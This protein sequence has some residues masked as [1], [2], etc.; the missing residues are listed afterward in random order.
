MKKIRNSLL[1]LL[2]IRQDEQPLVMNLM[3]FQFFQGAG[4]AFF[5]TATFAMFLER[6]TVNELPLVF[7]LA[8][9]LLYFTGLVYSWLEHRMKIMQLG[10]I[11][12]LMMAISFI[13]F[14]VAYSVNDGPELLTFMLAWFY[15]LYLLNNLQFWGVASIMF[16][17][18]QSKRLFGLIS[19]GDIPAKFIGYSLASL[20]VTTLGTENL[21][22]AGLFFMLCSVP[23]LFRIAKAGKHDLDS[24]G[25][26]MHEIHIKT[27]KLRSILGSFTS[28][29]LIEKTAILAFLF[30]LCL[31]LINFIFY[32]EVKT[33][34]HED[35]E[36]A[37]FIALFLAGSRIFALIVKMIFTGRMIARLGFRRSLLITP[38]VL[39]LFAL[40]IVFSSK[41]SGNAH[42][43]FYI[44]GMM[45]ISADILNSAIHF[46]GFL[47]L[48]QPLSTHDRLRAH[49]IVKGIMDPF[50]YFLTG[51]FLLLMLR[52]IGHINLFTLNYVLLGLLVFW[53]IGIYQV[54]AEYLRTLVQ[55][56]TTRTFSNDRPSIVDKDAFRLI[57]GKMN[58]GSPMEKIYLLKMLVHNH[59][60]PEL[61]TLIS[62]ALLDPAAAV[63]QE[64]IKVAVSME[65]SV[66][67]EILKDFIDREEDAALIEQ[68]LFAL[69]RISYD[70]KLVRGLNAHHNENV[71][72][73]AISV[74]L[75]H[76]ECSLH[77]HA[78]SYLHTLASDLDPRKRKAAANIIGKLSNMH[79]PVILSTLI[80]DKEEEVSREAIASAG[81]SAREE[82]IRVLV[83]LLP[84]KSNEVIE[85]LAEAGEVAVP[86]ISDYIRSGKCSDDMTEKLLRLLGR[87][88]G[89]PGSDALTSLVQLLPGKM[90]AVV[91]ALRKA[92]FR[93]EARH[94]PL[95][96]DLINAQLSAS[97]NINELLHMLAQ[98][99]HKYDLLYRALK[100]EKDIRRESLLDLFSFLYDRAVLAKIKR[101]LISGK[102]E[103]IANA[104]ELIEM[105][106]PGRIALPFLA[107]FEHNS[108]H[109]NTGHS[110]HKELN[111][112]EWQH[113][114]Y[115]LLT[116]NGVPY[117]AWTKACCLHTL[118]VHK[119]KGFHGIA[120]PYRNSENLLL[121]ETADALVLQS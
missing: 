9:V 84:E 98:G 6:F 40:M 83:G 115:S 103:S 59:D 76:P 18:R 17:V 27:V 93:A 5:F 68:S 16:D 118:S 104:C 80:H 61:R 53:V 92:K 69:C 44:F 87:I 116:E 81:K 85:A 29:K 33:A 96:E 94:V 50:A 4:I 78:K 1:K 49:N 8:A 100:I 67:R 46:P 11:V 77:E 113:V 109:Q 41:F 2:N 64:A 3:V 105:T 22:F 56:I 47:T 26:S 21:L 15:V 23:F 121:R 37:R 97:A 91:E 110:L 52:L 101:G 31:F 74:M 73:S 55:S 19:S 60:V 48:I 120:E 82:V 42:L 20:L 30:S 79:F 7:I 10:I 114:C 108:D 106:L 117:N 66:A 119:L 102:K 36:M 111:P 38:V 58:D 63:K 71:R 25:P 51:V 75:M 65:T 32:A 70:E 72:H 62:Q 57:Q 107:H 99:Q 24:H 89:E 13:F 43:V 34:Y 45:A 54:N 112:G 39:A 86:A 12:T 14:R 35:E 88:G 28:N 90:S 95:I